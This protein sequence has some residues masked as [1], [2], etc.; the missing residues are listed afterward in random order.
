MPT[1]LKAVV[2]IPAR[3]GSTRFPGKPL[4]N[5]SG[6]P[7]IQWV[8]ERAQSAKSISEVIVATDDE[9]ILNTVKSFGGKAVLTS[10]D[11]VSG[12]DRIAEAAKDLDCDIVINVQ[13]DEPLIPS[14]NI[15]LLVTPFLEDK[16][17]RVTT[18][19]SRI[20][21]DHEI[22]DPNV[23]KVTSSKT[24]FA[25]YFSRSP[26]PYLRDEW[27]N[28][29]RPVSIETCRET[30][31]YKHIGAYGFRKSFLMEYT[32]M[33][34][35][36]LEKAEK[37]EQLRI[38]ENGVPIYVVET[39]LGSIGVDRKEDLEKVEALLNQVEPVN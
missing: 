14:A 30:T 24:G 6:K 35:S 7:M 13:G 36:P 23:V 29:E 34:E 22:L 15:D 25:L 33:P 19:K 5:L 1:K 26:I 20:L 31:F 21:D 3:W 16:L 4:E 12:T 9:R 37:L 17:I 38:L 10:A 28:E 8:V 27:K 11:H 2:I 32:S 39:K 18:L